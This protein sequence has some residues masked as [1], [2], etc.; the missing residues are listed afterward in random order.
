VR[1][2]YSSDFYAEKADTEARFYDPIGTAPVVPMLIELA[3]DFDADGWPLFDADN[4]VPLAYGG[5]PQ[6]SIVP[7]GAWAASPL[8]LARIGTAIERSRRPYL[9]DYAQFVAMSQDQ[10]VAKPDGGHFGLG[11]GVTDAGSLVHG[12][13]VAGGWAQYHWGRAGLR[14]PHA[15]LVS[16]SDAARPRAHPGVPRRAAVRH[17]KFAE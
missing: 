2:G 14:R 10:S 15:R 11:F 6:K 7:V 16:A 13:S 1:F 5:T 4:R 9:L 3:D 12:G 17:S 8:A